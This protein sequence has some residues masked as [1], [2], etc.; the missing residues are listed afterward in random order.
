MARSQP[1]RFGS[2]SPEAAFSGVWRLIVSKDD[3]YIGASTAS[4]AVFKI[5]LHKSGV[6]VLA[7]TQQSGATFEAGNRRAKKWTRPLEHVQGVT[8]GPSIFVPHTS[9]GSRPLP[10][11]EHR[12]AVIWYQGPAAGET[13]EFSLHLVEPRIR[14]DWNPSETVL[15]EVPL[16][17]GGL[18]VLLAPTGESPDGFQE[19]VEKILRENVFRVSDPGAF[20]GGS[21]L[22]FTESCDDL[23]IPI[24]TDLPVPIGPEDGH[25]AAL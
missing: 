12:D 25:T 9:L 24:V 21:L 17:H 11:D 13:V 3:V 5:S 2:G 23:R 7:A 4:M 1:I 22:W 16:A 14:T 20:T 19:T 10:P 15:A 18:V 8:K 6:W